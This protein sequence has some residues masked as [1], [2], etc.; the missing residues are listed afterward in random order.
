M[1]LISYS[2]LFCDKYSKRRRFCVA[3]T[4]YTAGLSPEV[5]HVRGSYSTDSELQ[6]LRKHT[7]VLHY[8][9]CSC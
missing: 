9:S 1:D 6:Y 2:C 7:D 5:D 4:P 8:R 3:E